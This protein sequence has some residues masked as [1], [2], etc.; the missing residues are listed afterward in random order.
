LVNPALQRG[1]GR[2]GGVLQC[3]DALVAEEALQ[4]GDVPT[5]REA[6]A[7][8]VRQNRGREMINQLL[9]NGHDVE[10]ERVR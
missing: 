3:D 2:L 5:Q 9:S 1:G 8:T 4:V 7:W 10:R 6:E